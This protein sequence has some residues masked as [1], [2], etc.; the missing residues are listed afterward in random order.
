MLYTHVHCTPIPINA[1]KLPPGTKLWPDF[2]ISSFLALI[3]SINLACSAIFPSR[4]FFSSSAAASQTATNQRVPL[5]QKVY[6]TYSVYPTW[7]TPSTCPQNCQSPLVCPS[8]FPDFAFVIPGCISG[9]ALPRRARPSTPV[10]DLRC[11]IS[12][13]WEGSVS[14]SDEV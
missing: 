13:H 12:H 2:R 3:S 1:H 9:R 11:H 10:L 5:P 6:Q 7:S 8:D 4:I 14:C